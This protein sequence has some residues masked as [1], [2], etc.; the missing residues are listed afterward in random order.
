[1]KAVEDGFKAIYEQG[2]QAHIIDKMQTRS[3]L[4]EVVDYK[5]YAAFDESIF[6]FKLGEDQ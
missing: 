5:K 6:N 3:R 1:M 4:Y 2:T